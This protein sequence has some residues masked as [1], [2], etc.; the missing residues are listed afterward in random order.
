[1]KMDMLRLQDQSRITNFGSYYI[2]YQQLRTAENF[3]ENHIDER[4]VENVKNGSDAS[5]NGRL[6]RCALPKSY[7][8]VLEFTTL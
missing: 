8:D 5:V 4:R 6:L 7:I 3:V 1:M 2:E